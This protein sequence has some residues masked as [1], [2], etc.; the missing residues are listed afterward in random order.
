MR[1]SRRP[2]RSGGPAQGRALTLTP[3]TL[4]PQPEPQAQL[5][6][7]TKPSLKYPYL[8]PQPTLTRLPGPPRGRA[9]AA[10][11]CGRT[12]S[13]Y[14][15]YPS[16]ATLSHPL[17]PKALPSRVDRPCPNPIKR[18]P[19]DPPN[20][21]LFP[22][23]WSR[24]AGAGGGGARQ[25]LEVPAWLGLGLGLGFASYSNPNPNPNP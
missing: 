9:N 22:T 1:R 3:T 14:I 20:Q 5:D 16:P 2:T 12:L 11:G 7:K 15:P 23:A 6:F 24:Q 21:E 25:S 18:H 19:T 4:T 8:N 13:P 10:T 17:T